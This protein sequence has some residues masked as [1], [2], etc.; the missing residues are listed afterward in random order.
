MLVRFDYP[1]SLNGLLD[2]VVRDNFNTRTSFPAMD[3]IENEH[4]SVVVA[5]L[6]GVKKEDLKISFEDNILSISGERKPLEIPQR[7]QILLN[8]MRVRDFDRAVR[9]SHEVDS[10][11]I[12]AEL[13]NG[14]LRVTV[15][16]A[17]EAKPKHI[18]VKVK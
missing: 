11:N 17:E 8:E 13:E 12:V 3:V 6:P 7:A 10:D 2:D 15:P 18:E 16:K 5:E 14:I 1:G 4:A 9:L